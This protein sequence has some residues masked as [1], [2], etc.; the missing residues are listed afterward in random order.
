[1]S[2]AEITSNQMGGP[3]GTYARKWKMHIECWSESLKTR[4]CMGGILMLRLSK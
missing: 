4:T 2:S 3:Y 1:M